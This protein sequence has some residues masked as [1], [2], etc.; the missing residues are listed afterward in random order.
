MQQYTNLNKPGKDISTQHTTNNISKMRNVIN[1]GQG[2]GH[3][4]VA[5][6]REGNAVIV[7][8][9]NVPKNYCLKLTNLVDFFSRLMMGSLEAR[10]RLLSN[11]SG[12]N[13]FLL[14]FFGLAKEAI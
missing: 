6:I 13:T 4:Q 8:N 3:K 12:V 5:T 7:V 2:R 10:R 1:V 9:K 11:S 14:S